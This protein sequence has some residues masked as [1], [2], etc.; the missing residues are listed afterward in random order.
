MK[1]KKLVTIISVCAILAASIGISF[2]F[3]GKNKLEIP[4]VSADPNDI[5]AYFM[6][7]A[8]EPGIDRLPKTYG[9]YRSSLTAIGTSS[10]FIASWVATDNVNLTSGGVVVGQ[11]ADGVWTGGPG[12]N[13]PKLLSEGVS[14]DPKI[15][16]FSVP[17]PNT[18]DEKIINYVVWSEVINNTNAIRLEMMT[19]EGWG[20]DLG[21]EAMGL[22]PPIPNGSSTQPALH[23]D[24]NGNP[25]VCW[26]AS[27][28][29]MNQIAVSFWRN[30]TWCTFDGVPG[31]EI[32]QIN[33]PFGR[34]AKEPTMLTN[35]LGEPMVFWS[36]GSINGNDVFLAVRKPTGWEKFGGGPITPLFQVPGDAFN[37]QIQYMSTSLDEFFIYWIDGELKITYFAR[38]KNNQWYGVNAMPAPQPIYNP[39]NHTPNNAVLLRVKKSTE[40]P[41]QISMTKLV[42]DTNFMLSIE[43][44]SPIMTE[45]FVPPPPPQ[46]YYIDTCLAQMGA[47]GWANPETCG[48]MNG[49]ECIVTEDLEYANALLLK[50]TRP[51]YL[52]SCTI[53][54]YGAIA[55]SYGP[56][57]G[58]FEGCKQLEDLP[59]GTCITSDFG[60]SVCA[61][62]ITTG[63]ALVTVN[64]SEVLINM[65]GDSVSGPTDVKIDPNDIIMGPSE[66][67]EIGIKIVGLTNILEKDVTLEVDG[68]PSSVTASF[69]PGHGVIASQQG[70]EATLK[71]QASANVTNSQINAKLL[72][73]KANGKVIGSYNMT[74]KLVVFN[75]IIENNDAPLKIFPDSSGSL[76]ILL[77]YS[78]NFN[79]TITP[80][81]GGDI[82][83]GMTITFDPTTITKSAGDRIKIIVEASPTIVPANYSFTVTLSSSDGST[84]NLFFTV[85]ISVF[86]IM[87]DEQVKYVN[88]STNTVTWEVYVVPVQSY[89]GTIEINFENIPPGFIIT[90]NPQSITS[91]GVTVTVLITATV[92]TGNFSNIFTM[93]A[94]SRRDD[95]ERMDLSV[96]KGKFCA[97]AEQLH[98]SLLPGDQGSWMIYIESFG[99]EDLT[100]QFAT[101]TIPSG[102][103]SCF[104][105]TSVDLTKFLITSVLFSAKVPSTESIKKYEIIVRVTG[106]SEVFDLKIPVLVQGFQVYMQGGSDISLDRGLSKLVRINIESY[107]YFQGEVELG[108]KVK[109]KVSWFRAEFGTNPVIC[110]ANGVAWTY[111]KLTL[112]AS[113]PQNAPPISFNVSGRAKGS[114]FEGWCAL[115]APDKP[116]SFAQQ[117]RKYENEMFG[118][119]S[120]SSMNPG[121]TPWPQLTPNNAPSCVGFYMPKFKILRQ[122]EHELNK[123]PVQNY[124][125]FIPYLAINACSSEQ[126]TKTTFQKID[127]AYYQIMDCFGEDYN[128]T[129]YYPSEEVAFTQE[130]NVD[131]PTL[132]NEYGYCEENADGG[133][134]QSLAKQIKNLQHAE[135]A[136]GMPSISTIHPQYAESVF[137]KVYSSEDSC[138][139]GDTNTNICIKDVR[140]FNKGTD[141]TKFNSKTAADLDVP[142]EIPITF[143]SFF[144]VELGNEIKAVEAQATCTIIYEKPLPNHS[145]GAE[146]LF[147]DWYVGDTHTHSKMSALRMTHP[148]YDKNTCPDSC[149]CHDG[150]VGPGQNGGK[151]T[152][153]G[154]PSIPQR[155]E[156]FREMNYDFSYIADHKISSIVTG[157]TVSD[158]WEKM[159]T[160]RDPDTIMTLSDCNG[161]PGDCECPPPLNCDKCVI[162]TLC[163]YKE[164]FSRDVVAIGS[165]KSTETAFRSYTDS[166]ILCGDYQCTGNLV[167][168]Y[169]GTASTPFTQNKLETLRISNNNREEPVFKPNEPTYRPNNKQLPEWKY[170]STIIAHPYENSCS[171]A[172]YE[173][174]ENQP[175]PNYVPIN[176]YY[177]KTSQD[178]YD[179]FVPEDPMLEPTLTTP[180]SG[181]HGFPWNYVTCYDNCDPW[182]N[183]P[184]NKSDPDFPP[185]VRPDMGMRHKTAMMDTNG[186]TN[187]DLPDIQR[188]P[189]IY[190]YDGM[191]L[192]Y[193]G[194][195][196]GDGPI[197]ITLKRWRQELMDELS[198]VTQDLMINRDAYITQWDANEGPPI[199]NDRDIWH[200]FPVGASNI[201]RWWMEPWN[202]YYG[203]NMTYIHAREFNAYP[204]DTNGTGT[205]L[206]HPIGYYLRNGKTVASGKGSF[207][208]MWLGATIDQGP[209]IPP[210]TDPI[211]DSKNIVF[212]P[213]DLI[214][215]EDKLKALETQIKIRIIAKSA[216][217]PSENDDYS[218][219]PFEARVYVGIMPDPGQRP[220]E[221]T[222]IKRYERGSGQDKFNSDNV[223]WSLNC[224]PNGGYIQKPGD[225]WW[226][227][228]DTIPCPATPP[229]P[230]D[231]FYVPSGKPWFIRA[232]VDFKHLNGQI[233]TVFLAPIYSKQ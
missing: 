141:Y 64:P 2:L 127:V 198:S 185:S 25:M 104:D 109:P 10:N 219:M 233:E 190:G 221:D 152:L 231:Y 195:F 135:M 26:V 90:S 94:S 57:P 3:S 56:T 76:D 45:L 28:Y 68:L 205:G 105:N 91:T 144:I 101:N 65:F 201:L 73:K 139:N 48:L 146:L 12:E 160:P 11:C 153:P 97:W 82:P 138:K 6:N 20:F 132:Y 136:I 149:D 87:C 113:T 165:G 96:K 71:L 226:Y 163:K 223:I 217:S 59:P 142:T 157:S 60:A 51:L 123:K 43:E 1:N 167:V 117:K 227:V 155:I 22:L 38:R 177:Q 7:M 66:E 120:K 181:H 75:A 19:D 174:K 216:W 55:Y 187:P 27:S 164:A 39:A 72:V 37:L 192:V 92:G 49:C 41:T 207:A 108:V 137:K 21:K 74:I 125:T 220:L 116:V 121:D 35:V 189:N 184:E 81:I 107:Q 30:N 18:P 148:S 176:P 13:E 98:D 162:D 47:S 206:K 197:P 31:Y 188:V 143:R 130:V 214:R 103:T 173:W 67:K 212:Q 210:Y 114:G 200:P 9:K 166:V 118:I 84:V 232:E 99:A 14:S 23:L 154:G 46:K 175:L 222:L 169:S 204:N 230:P 208:T 79:Y 158:S 126:C 129:E 17:I 4:K 178:I 196:D 93:K 95:I 191:E 115:R 83:T 202:I 63:D 16:S 161:L 145:Q 124:S 171:Q 186:V 85:S 229:Q 50:Y 8:G 106:G 15:Y 24:P 32:I 180:R 29:G 33:L 199:K 122:V 211:C 80:S 78:E 54:K 62:D 86:S 133:Q 44:Y 172:L 111:L 224:Q 102:W 218:N 119:I 140:I 70:F 225:Y 170:Y 100:A 34:F 36:D 58:L 194:T 128:F 69:N 52:L 193:E 110:Y 213:G 182:A 150:T 209:T 215:H 88:S 179:Y 42:L 151:I 168:N 77:T 156:E 5:P 40:Q 159:I 112:D 89:T 147:N 228:D 131:L 203:K 61:A 134:S 183:W 53:S